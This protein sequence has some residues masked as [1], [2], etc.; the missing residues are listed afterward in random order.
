MRVLCRTVMRGLCV[1]V[2]LPVVL[3]TVG[4]CA[5]WSWLWNDDDERSRCGYGY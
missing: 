5:F 2:V 3:L 1:L 4:L